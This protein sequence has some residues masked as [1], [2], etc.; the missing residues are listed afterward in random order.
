MQVF[1]DKTTAESVPGLPL[2]HFI[3]NRIYTDDSIFREERAR[4]FSKV[5]N[6][7]IHESEIPNPGSFKTV[8]VAG[9]PLLLVRQF[10]GSIKGFYNICRHRQ[11]PLARSCVGETKAFQCFYHLWTYGLDGKLLGVTLPEGY[12]NTGFQKE[13]FGLIE[14]RVSE[15]AGMIF[16]CLSDETEP[17]DQFLGEVAPALVRH[18]PAVGL[19]IFHFHQAELKTNWKLF[20]ENN[21]K[22][23]HT[24]LHWSNRS[25]KKWGQP[26]FAGRKMFLTNGHN[27]YT[28]EGNRYMV[29]GGYNDIGLEERGDHLFPGIDKNTQLSVHLFP[30]V[31]FIIRSTAL[32]IDRL[33]PVSPGL[34]VLESRGF[35]FKGDSPEVRSLRIKHHNEIWG[36]SGSNLPEDIIATESQWPM[37][38][39]GAVRYSII[40]RE[41]DVMNDET[42][43]H[44]YKEWTRR[45]GRAY[46]DPFGEMI[47]EAKL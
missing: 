2:T 23:Y 44:Y 4:I 30:D 7:V 34:T 47:G 28:P 8:N 22:P 18:I 27:C 15:A 10:N 26:E 29:D 35:G 5:W 13:D 43:R 16:V 25:A 36:Y 17:L 24:A 21:N 40:A 31:L 6:F 33:I 38:A 11:A 14:V 19:E 45:I 1:A 41:G 32:R 42:M 39:S 9:Y 3:D 37:I 46:W 12:Q 20:Q